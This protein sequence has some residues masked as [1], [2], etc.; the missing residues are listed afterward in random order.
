MESPSCWVTKIRICQDLDSECVLKIPNTEDNVLTHAEQIRA[1]AYKM[2]GR[3]LN[4]DAIANL[5][6]QGPKEETRLAFFD[7][8]VEKHGDRLNK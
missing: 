2:M 6:D 4:R 8:I 5:I 3:R 1:F 7:E